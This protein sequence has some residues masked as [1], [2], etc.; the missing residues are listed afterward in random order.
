[1]SATTAATGAVITVILGILLLALSFPFCW[2]G[3]L[4]RLQAVVVI[5]ANF[6]HIVITPVAFHFLHPN[7]DPIDNILI[8]ANQKALQCIPAS[9]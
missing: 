8:A 6:I 9:C 7:R 5:V 2:C 1:M 3:S 4:L